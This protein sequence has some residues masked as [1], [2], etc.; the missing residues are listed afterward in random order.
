VFLSGDKE[1]TIKKDI[2]QELYKWLKEA[3]ML[4]IFFYNDLNDIN[5]IGLISNNL[6]SQNE[7]NMF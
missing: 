2:L 5:K 1:I 3:R 6:F 7:W 4:I